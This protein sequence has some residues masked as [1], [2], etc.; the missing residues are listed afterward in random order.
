MGCSAIISYGHNT[1]LETTSFSNISFGKEA[2]Q[3]TN[4]QTKT[5]THSLPA[6]SGGSG[7]QNDPFIIAVPADLVSLS[8]LVD[9]ERITCKDLFFVLEKDIDM[10]GITMNPIG[11]N[12]GADGHDIRVF[13]G[14]FDG[15]NHR[16]SNL[17]M[18]FSGRDYL[19]V[20]LFGVVRNASIKNLVIESSTFSADAVVS[21]LAA[22][23]TGGEIINC[24][25]EKDVMV[26]D[27]K[28]AFAAGLVASNFELPTKIVRCTNR[29][30][31]NSTA[32]CVAGIL[33]TSSTMGC[34]I[35]ECVNFGNIHTSSSYSAGILSWVE[36][37]K[38]YVRDC[39]N[40]G[41]ISCD[42]GIAG[43]IVAMLNIGKPGPVSIKNSYNMGV[44]M[45]RDVLGDPIFAKPKD[46]ASRYYLKNN[47]Y[48][49]D[50]YDGTAFESVGLS[51]IEMK[52]QDFADKLNANREGAP[53]MLV[54]DM[55][56]PVGNNNTLDIDNIDAAKPHL[57]IEDG[58]VTAPEDYFIEGI[59]NPEGVR[60]DVIKTLL[61]GCYIVVMQNK[62]NRVERIVQKIVIK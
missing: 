16:I 7:K 3:Y 56:L 13:S 59:Y 38:V 33:A 4:E 6:F 45:N 50:I 48:C 29:A 5:D 24:H 35:R 39:A 2:P 34:Q 12:F 44:V 49:K 10:K 55:V 62:D 57:A 36:D 20:A 60:I 43:G 42:Q 53:W 30:Q 14:S 54:E 9:D 15:N 32:V 51:R 25:T 61:P 1:E 52:T 18:E 46:N 28:H 31:V 8:K 40:F 21:A 17:K 58:L 22:V 19:G 23:V 47:Y 11:T 26:N 27:N 41:Q 37:G